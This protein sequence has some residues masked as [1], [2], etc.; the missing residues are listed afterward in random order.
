MSAERF[1][2][3]PGTSWRDRPEAG[4]VLGIRFMMM[5]ARL[6]GRRVLH[7]LLFPITGYFY[8]VR[9]EERAASRAFL[10]R[11]LPRPV[12]RRDVFRHFLTF[13]RMTADRVYFL[14]DQR[15]EI[16]VRFIGAEA[17][18][19]LVDQSHRGV[20]LAAHMGSFEA[21]RVL[22]PV[23]GGV[24]LH[25]V[26]DR[27]VNEHIMKALEAL[28]PEFASLIIDAGQPAVSLG[29]RIGEAMAE[30]NWVGFLADRHRPGDRTAVCR[31]LG[32][33]TQFPVGPFVI[34]SAFKAPVVGVF[35]RCVGDGYEI[36]CE[37]L[38]RGLDIPRRDRQQAL[39]QWAQTYADRLAHHAREA[40]Y[41]WFNF[42][43]FW[44]GS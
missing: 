34:A 15:L 2:G 28:N 7:A 42:Y 14:A 19:A 38:S 8:L 37:I 41:S 32:G 21:A 40:P 24:H 43:D 26:L 29:L 16:A 27:R 13:A 30:G 22:G 35:P 5:L 12:R 20:F 18:Q 6:L 39:G 23:L 4:T 44:A 25:I 31:F 1:V 9:R 36:H 3:A 33:S 17:L 10:A 11:V